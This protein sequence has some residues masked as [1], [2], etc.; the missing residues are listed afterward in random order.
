MEIPQ[1]R[2][3]AVWEYVL[4]YAVAHN[5]AAPSIRDFIRDKVDNIT[6]T[7]IVEL[8]LTKLEDMGLITRH[9]GDISQARTIEIV[10]G[11]YA[12]PKNIRENKEPYEYTET[13]YPKTTIGLIMSILTRLDN[14]EDL[15]QIVVATDDSSIKLV[16]MGCGMP[17]ISRD[18]KEWLVE[19]EDTREAV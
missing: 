1:E 10:G 16:A 6:S 4:S 11:V 14:G 2:T 5:G 8:H 17:I 9:H 13:I 18:M 3:K 15:G 12:I 7:S 19:E